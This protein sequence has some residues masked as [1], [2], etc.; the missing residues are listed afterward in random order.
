MW[1]VTNSL[2]KSLLQKKKVH[3]NGKSHDT[4]S[5]VSCDFLVKKILEVKKSVKYLGH[6][7]KC[8]PNYYHVN[9]M[10]SKI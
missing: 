3:K 8:V 5:L 2:K 1:M 6:H 4:L 10:K 7:K 9:K